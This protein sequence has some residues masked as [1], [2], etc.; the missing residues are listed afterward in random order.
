M[1]LSPAQIDAGFAQL[2]AER[3]LARRMNEVRDP[4]FWRALNPELSITEF[5][6]AARRPRLPVTADAIGRCRRQVTED[7]YLHTPPL[8]PSDE[9]ARLARGIQRVVDEGLPS[10]LACV[11]DEYFNIFNGL[12]SFFEPLLGPNY[13]MV[14]Q[15]L[16]AFHVPAGDDGRTLWTAG[17]PHRDRMRPDARTMAHDVPSILTLW[18][19]LA[20]V[21]TDHSCIYVVPASC[22]EDYFTP[23]KD[24][25]EKK[26]RLQDI[27]ALPARA[28]SILGWSSHLIHWGSRPSAFVTTPRIAATIYFQRADVPAWHPFSIDPARPVPFVDRL[29][30]IDHSMARPGLLGGRTVAGA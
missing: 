25:D 3:T 20:D 14:T 8:V 16:W 24:L 10:V 12:E 26:I 13:Y 6:L 23:V 7:G 4:D 28:G 2:R 15:G 17:S 18:M 11:Y 30:W 22:D 27:R 5:P 1:A 21:T 29:T 19:P 9:V